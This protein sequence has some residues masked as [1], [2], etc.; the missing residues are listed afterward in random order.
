MQLLK[1]KFQ[2]TPAQPFLFVTIHWFTK[3]QA[4]KGFTG[5]LA[6]ETLVQNTMTHFRIIKIIYTNA[7]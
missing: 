5:A 3:C 4:A 6:M 1:T 2:P 7:L